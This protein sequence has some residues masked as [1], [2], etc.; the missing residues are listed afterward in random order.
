MSSHNVRLVDDVERATDAIIEKLGKTIVLGMPL[1]LGKP[2]ELANALFARAAKDSSLKLKI[3]TALSLEVPT[4][5]NG[6]EAAFMGPFL[7]RVF[8]GVPQLDYINALRK[9]KLPPN[10]E[11]CE[12]FFKPGS[13]MTNLHA[14]QHY[15]SSNYSHAA[16]D[17]FN[18]G[19]NLTAQIICKRETPQG[20]RYSLSCNPDTAPELL[21]LLKASGRPHL[22]VGLV[23][24]SLP[25]MY[26]DAE[27]GPEDF[28]LIIDHPR[29][30]TP[31]F[32][33]PKMPV[34]TPDYMIGLNASALIKDGGTLQI[35]IGALGDA[36]VYAAKLRHEHNEVYQQT[37]RAAGVLT[38]SEKLVGDIGG[39]EPFQQGLY[40]ATEMFVDG[41]LH[42]YKAGILKRRVYDFWAL[43]QLVNEGRCDPDQLKPEVLDGLESLGVRT[44]RTRDFAV[45]QHHGLFN[46]QTRYDLGYIV[47]PDGERV[48]GNV[49][50]P[51]SRQVIGDRCLGKK[52]RHGIVLHGG[53]FLGPRDFYDG[54]RNMSE[55]QRRQ[56]CMTGVYK[57][58]QLDHNPRLYKQQRLH[59]RFINTGIM[60]TLSGAVCSDGLE[61]GRVVSGVGGQ[62]NFVAMAHQLPT[63]RSILMIR[64][65]RDKEGKTTE[66]SSNIV[67]NYGHTTIARHLRDIVIT[68][69]GIAELRSKTD[70]EVIKALLNVADSRFQQGLLE[71]AKKAGKLEVDYQIPEQYRQ[72]LPEKLEEKLA[73][74]KKQGL[75]PAFPLGCDLTEDELKLGKALKGVKARAAAGKLRAM[76]DAWKVKEIPASAKPYLERMQLTQPQ[77]LQDK[78]VQKLL[79]LELQTTGAI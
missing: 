65:V 49:A 38:Q 76:L 72:N 50:E 47:A 35:G 44:I 60:V 21:E 62:Y 79:V 5:A 7:E 33:T 16:R 30:T 45:L 73:E 64:A 22:A 11:V 1:G 4:P 46:D 39:T 42:L 10:V 48:I 3:L 15:I 41:L 74:C 25:Y 32:S 36:I 56:I 71:R 52:L 29:Y 68:E 55:D 26:N 70:S 54:L 31:L 53:F 63:G 37:L 23:N 18:N 40:G 78:I 34:M 9:G 75:F 19:C 67:F 51:H 6:L 77:T 58:N 24:Q 13:F 69:Y 2:A 59:A 43:Q 66:P 12:F 20:P 57:V 17:V 61:D 8:G 28:D 14:Q 27:V